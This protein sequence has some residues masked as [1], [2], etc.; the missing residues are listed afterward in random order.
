MSLLSELKHP[1]ERQTRL[2]VRSVD[3][4]P[5]ETSVGEYGTL[6]HH[7]RKWEYLH[8][9]NFVLTFSNFINNAFSCGFN[10]KNNFTYGPV[11]ELKKISI[12]RNK[13]KFGKNV[14]W[15]VHPC[16]SKIAP[17]P[18]FHAYLLRFIL[19]FFSFLHIKLLLGF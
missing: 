18:N 11:V 5:N 17:A 9:K 15:Y 12:P 7:T 14:L 6:T 16:E 1:A 10:W 3:P 4:T 2:P 8:S 13:I 19:F